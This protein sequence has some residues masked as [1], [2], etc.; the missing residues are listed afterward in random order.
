MP[1]AFLLPLLVRRRWPR[2]TAVLIIAGVAAVYTNPMWAV[3]R[4]RSELAMAV[5]LFTLVKRGGRRFAALTAAAVLVLDSMWG[6][7]WASPRR[8]RR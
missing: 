1:L 8:T 4:G 3:D 7:R 2:T 5:V 6:F